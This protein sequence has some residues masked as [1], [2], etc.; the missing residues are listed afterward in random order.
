VPTLLVIRG[1]PASGKTAL[2]RHA[3]AREP[4]RWVVVEWDRLCAMLHP[5]PGTEPDE[6]ATTDVALHAL[7]RVLLA[8]GR[9]VISPD[10]NLDPD[11]LADLTA[12]AHSVPDVQV[13]Y[14]DLTSVTLETCQYHPG[15]TGSTTACG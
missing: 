14:A 11:R 2:A 3:I 6:V 12:V 13:Q 9:D 7:V 10:Q 1:L 8:T 4:G 15:P 5:V